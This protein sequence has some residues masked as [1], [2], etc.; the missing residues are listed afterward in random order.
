MGPPPGTDAAQR[1]ALAAADLEFRTAQANAFESG[2]PSA[3]VVR[4]A[5]ASHAVFLSN[6]ADVLREMLAFLGKVR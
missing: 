4:L 3:R 5:N 1:A 2:N 6:E